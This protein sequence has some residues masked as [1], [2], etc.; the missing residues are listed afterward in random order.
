MR[1]YIIGIMITIV[2]GTAIGWYHSEIREAEA[3]GKVKV[4]VEQ[5]DSADQVFQD[6]LLVWVPR[7]SIRSVAIQALSNDLTVQSAAA[8]VRGEEA[9]EAILGTR[10]LISS[11]R[12][13]LKTLTATDLD[14]IE[15]G[16][17]S[18]EEANSLCLIALSGCEVLSDS[19]HLALFDT[20][21]Q[22]DRSTL[23]GQRQGEVILRLQGIRHPK[24]GTVGWLGWGA[25]AVIAI[26]ATLK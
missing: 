13:S 25:A 17:D 9:L 16:I 26:L 7:D 3:R 22:L 10:S 23:L 5:V 8:R 6:S 19:M 12:D 11:L 18:L 1:M 15:A 14:Q 21:A 4:L 24:V 20:K 2:A